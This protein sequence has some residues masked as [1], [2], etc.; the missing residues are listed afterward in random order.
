[1]MRWLIG[2]SLQSRLLVAA[3]AAGLIFY[4]I[5]QLDEMPVDILP[6]FSRPYVEIQTEA[7]GLSASEVEALITVP[8]EADMLNGAPWVDEIRSS[9]IPGL[10]SIVMIFE[11]GT[12]V[13]RARQ[14]VQERMTEVHTL[15]NVAKS[16][17]MINPVSSAGRVMMI[18]LSSENLSL[19]DMS[20]LAR[21]N[22]VPRLMG[23][24][25][26]ANVSIWGERRRQL[27]VQV[28]PEKL[29][30]LDVTLMQVVSTTGNALWFSP[31]TFLNASTPG[32]AG[33]IDTP[34]QRLGLRHLSPISTPEEL[35]QI[36]VEGS[37]K[38]L[39][40]VASVVVDHQPLIG[41]AI[42][43][44]E[45]SLVLVVE[46]FPWANT[47]EVTRGTEEA[48]DAMS[49]GLAGLEIDSTLFRPA[50]YIEMASRN[51]TVALM[52][53]AA[54]VA[55]ALGAFFLDA[56]AALIG[57]LAILL[58]FMTA[59][60]VL[61]ISGAAINAMVLAGLAIAMGVL[62]DDA[63]AD[64]ENIMRRLRQHRQASSSKSFAR[65]VLEASL[66]L[67]STMLY[68]TLIMLLVASP[69]LFFGA[70]TGAFLTPVAIAYGLALLASMLIALTV[71]PA[72][73]I[74][75]L[76]SS[77]L[78]G[79]QSAIV[80][81]LQHG[82]SSALSRL[83][84]NPRPAF[85]AACIIGLGGLAMLLML[86]QT[87]LVPT[88][89]ER[90]LLVEIEAAPGTSHPA[91]SRIASQATRELRS[92][93]GV[94]SV[95][96]DVGR[97]V[98]SDSINDVNT[99]DLWISMDRD[100]DYDA[101]VDRIRQVMSGYAGLDIDVGTYL[102]TCVMDPR[103]EGTD[104]DIVVR[105]YG[106]DWNILR[107]KA[108]EVNDALSEIDGISYSKTELPIEEPQV[109][110][111]LDMAAAMEHGIKPGDV[112]RAAATLLSGLEV[113][114]IF[115]EQK[116]FDVVVWGVP[117]TRDNLT[118]IRNLLIDTPN[119][120]H[121]SLKDVADVRIVPSPT[122]INR[123]A[124]SRHVDVVANVGERGLASVA[125]DVQRRLN[126]VDFPLEYRAELLEGSA[127]R[128]ADR[129]SAIG[130]VIAAVV[131]IFLVLQACIGSWSLAI[132]LFLT[133]PAAIAGGAL[134]ALAFGGTL[135]LGALLGL[136]AVLGIAVRNGLLL[137]RHYQRLAANSDEFESGANA[138]PLRTSFEQ[139]SRVDHAAANDV[140][141]FAP[142]TVQ[143][144]TWERFTPILMTAVITA[145]AVLPLVMMGDVPGSEVL[146]PMAVVMLGGLV[147][148]TLFSLFGIPAI[149]L[150]FTP[151]RGAEL[152][153]LES[154][155]VGEEELRESIS[156][157][158]A[159]QKELHPTNIN[160]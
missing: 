43:N 158:G 58:S 25:G 140:A 135:S 129:R 13:M 118:T 109:E 96:A 97:A 132:V 88:F 65:I 49:P 4:G 2:A 99:G 152:E 53:A 42:I 87:S 83:V 38:R 29:R 148:S 36:T 76:P 149:F 51:L 82:Y 123:E 128:L 9:S 24:D 121:V 127:E 70:I 55:V 89:K 77:P 138:A 98:M 40:E 45:P 116:V 102:K 37:D 28:D 73:C 50:T 94:R 157:A 78:G 133:L 3:V 160:Y 125:G 22:I 57:S 23:V 120:G 46:K 84:E 69:A 136:I 66:E 114:Y 91:M 19:I 150:L 130:S 56:R 119:G 26:V 155:L 64:V 63:V 100:A 18:G 92:I 39:G 90:D 27:Q 35:A 95:S 159:P 143:R 103:F 108:Q 79:S 60:L 8:L 32:T 12:D 101:T 6:E 142:G 17:V 112:R 74:M 141:I 5:T 72:L 117:E 71:T 156:T 107:A 62:V 15:P 16:P 59:V 1:M 86:E 137:I 154:T 104:N 7:L 110:I 20:V 11:P 48:L 122:I 47:M 151:T 111:E 153:D 75:L 14:M 85:A 54:L 31:L 44:E 10:S 67:R 68:A 52:I 124:V 144:G 93:P 80:G 146:R 126:D 61:Y 33:F 21:W 81:Q 41:D 147:T 131:G 105:I 30:E 139:R 34:N 106:D 113:G 134:A 115:E 145:A